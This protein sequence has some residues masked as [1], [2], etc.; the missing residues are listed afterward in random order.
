MILGFQQEELESLLAAQAMWIETG[1]QASAF[2]AKIYVPTGQ[3]P[4]GQG[5]N[6]KA[7]G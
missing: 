3:C 7:I 6:Y 1:S 5:K 2:R 4:K